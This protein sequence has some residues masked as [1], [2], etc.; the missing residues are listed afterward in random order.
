[1]RYTLQPD[2]R[3]TDTLQ[4][5]AIGARGKIEY[6]GAYSLS[7]LIRSHV[8]RYARDHHD[9]AR[10]LGALPTRHLEDRINGIVC[11]SGSNAVDIPIPG[12]NRVFHD[13]DIYPRR[14][15]VLTIPI[16]RVSYGVRAGRLADEGWD[17]FRVSTRGGG[18]G[19]GILFGR[20]AGEGKAIALYLLRSHAR[21]RRDRSMLPGDEE[22]RKT[23][24]AA[25]A[26]AIL[27]RSAS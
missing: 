23:S 18:P 22:M 17:F 16:N 4:A 5:L 2:A 8:I 13:V 11:P 27:R 26:R 9:S 21:L 3:L 20:K 6:A 19:A 1:M 15:K 10:R 25:V 14:K 12:F 7:V 24:A